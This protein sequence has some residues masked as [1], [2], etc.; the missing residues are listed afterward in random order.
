[1]TTVRKSSSPE[2]AGEDLDKPLWGAAAIGEE[3]GKTESQAFHL[4]EA[5][6]LPATKIG[7]QWASTKRR[8]RQRF[9]GAA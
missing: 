1:M 4:L 6:H 7:R 2:S 9:A 8:L 5:G 3:I